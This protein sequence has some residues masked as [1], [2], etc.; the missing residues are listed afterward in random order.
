[1]SATITKAKASLHCFSC[2]WWMARSKLSFGIRMIMNRGSTSWSTFW[3]NSIKLPQR[4]PNATPTDRF[5]RGLKESCK[6]HF[7]GHSARCTSTSG[8]DNWCSSGG[9]LVD[10]VSPW[11]S[12]IYGP[13]LFY[14]HKLA[15]FIL[16]AAFIQ[17]E[18]L[19]L[20]CSNG[21]I[22]VQNP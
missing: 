22:Q 13:R 17:D 21:I 1:M 6:M 7:A 18:R 4:S 20:N 9:R 14:F 3:L 2:P 11:H 12:P 10:M 19:P 8:T 15:Y 16:K 5:C